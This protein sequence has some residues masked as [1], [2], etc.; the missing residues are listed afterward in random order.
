MSIGAYARARAHT[1][2][3]LSNDQALPSAGELNFLA[4]ATYDSLRF[5]EVM[6]VIWKR[7]CDSPKCWRHVYKSLLVLEHLL[8]YGNPSVIEQSRCNMYILKR[9]ENF[10]LYEVRFFR[11]FCSPL[12]S[13]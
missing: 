8:V 1:H 9:L 11:I 10:Q 2:I 5:V 12:H 7:L 4:A 13:F 6:C 3:L